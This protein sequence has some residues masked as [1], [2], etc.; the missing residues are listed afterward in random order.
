M[1]NLPS[2]PRIEQFRSTMR[3]KTDDT[4]RPGHDG[5]EVITVVHD[6]I[7]LRSVIDGTD[8]QDRGSMWHMDDS[9]PDEDTALLNLDTIMSRLG[10]VRA[11]DEDWHLIQDAPEGAEHL[12]LAD[13]H[14]KPMPTAM[15]G[16]HRTRTMG[17]E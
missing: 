14:R 17:G 6:P 3:A 9:D 12:I 8:E 11:D 4:G 7:N 2:D 1:S 10:W 13:F 5:R 16:Q 15:D